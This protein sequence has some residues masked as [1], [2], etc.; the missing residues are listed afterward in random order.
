MNRRDLLLIP[1]AI[2]LTGCPGNSVPPKTKDQ[3]YAIYIALMSLFAPKP[4]DDPMTNTH[5]DDLL[6]YPYSQ[7][8]TM[9][10]EYYPPVSSVP[11]EY[12]VVYDR[13]RAALTADPISEK[14]VR[15]GM[16]SFMDGLQ[17]LVGAGT[18]V[19]ENPYPGGDPNNC[20]DEPTVDAMANRGLIKI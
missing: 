6:K 8:S 20:F 12:G 13:I 15:A 11:A 2:L 19:Q 4:G 17:V 16:K 18:A 1:P 14:K 10:K 5:L 9:A 7:V 3:C